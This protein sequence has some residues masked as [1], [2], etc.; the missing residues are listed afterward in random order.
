MKGILALVVL[1]G[2]NVDT[3]MAEAL[4]DERA[5]KFTAGY[6]FLQQHKYQE[7]RT[8]FEAGLQQYPADALAH[9][10]LGDACQGLK[11]WACAEAHYETSLE[12]N[13]K[14]PVAGLA[15]QR[16][17]KA[18][19]WRLLDNGKQVVNEPNVPPQQLTQ[20][21]NTLETA[22][23][24]GLDDEQRAIYQQLHVKIQ[25]KHN[26][27]YKTASLIQHLERSMVLVPAGEFLM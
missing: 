3:T 22:N 2:L 1:L 23:K 10:Y 13:A 27:N 15:K 20:A 25:Q 5:K 14:S 9:F 24:L 11:A 12:L 8:A 17:R 19:V 4:F 18:T 16:A 6:D 26:V 21:E 7:A